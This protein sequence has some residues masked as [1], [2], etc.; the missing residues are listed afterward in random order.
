[1]LSKGDA[2]I[3]SIPR[4]IISKC[5]WGC[6]KGLL[7]SKM[8]FLVEAAIAAYRAILAPLYNS[9]CIFCFDRTA[10]WSNVLAGAFHYNRILQSSV[11]KCCHQS[12][13][14]KCHHFRSSFPSCLPKRHTTVIAF[15]AKSPI[16]VHQPL[17]SLLDNFNLGQPTS[18]L[19]LIQVPHDINLLHLSSV[20][21]CSFL[22]LQ[23]MSQLS[24]A[25]SPPCS[26]NLGVTG[27]VRITM[28]QQKVMNHMYIIAVH[29]STSFK[30]VRPVSLDKWRRIGPYQN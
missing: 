27:P 15:V 7:R 17:L 29:V 13:C 1:M 9:A 22:H 30:F 4:L 10:R 6:K 20:R 23:Q 28:K 21:P 25:T 12:Q 8:T 18:G 5:F 2:A 26:L 3:C 19:S 24:P 16:H 11:C 14:A